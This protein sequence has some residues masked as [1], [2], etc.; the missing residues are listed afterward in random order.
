VVAHARGLELADY[1]RQTFPEAAGTGTTKPLTVVWSGGAHARGTQFGRDKFSIQEDLIDPSGAKTAREA[2]VMSRSIREA[3]AKALQARGIDPGESKEGGVSPIGI[4]TINEAIAITI[5]AAKQ[6]QYAGGKDF[7]LR[8]DAAAN[9][10]REPDGRYNF[11]GQ[12]LDTEGLLAVYLALDADFPGLIRSIED[13][14][15]EDDLKGWR[16]IKQV[17]PHWDLVAD[18]LTATQLDL[19]K[20]YE[21]LYDILLVKP[22][23]AGSLVDTMR[24]IAL[25]KSLGKEVYPSHRSI[26]A[27]TTYEEADLLIADIAHAVGAPYLK[28]MPWQDVRTAKVDRLI[29]LEERD[30]LAEAMPAPTADAVGAAAGEILSTADLST[31]D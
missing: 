12:L 19:V 2:K 29:Y 15:A 4:G 1:L 30:A 25:A 16:R 24:V 6:V 31:S 18:D 5:D 26:E 14:F 23:Q 8:F 28:T 9:S 11:D 27:G 20:R 22:N 13:P 17:L 3:L 10:F 21:N 7:H